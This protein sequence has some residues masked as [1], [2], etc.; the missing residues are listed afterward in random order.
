M[1]E[2]TPHL[3]S[4]IYLR[5]VSIF[6][7]NTD[8]NLKIFTKTKPALDLFSEPVL[9][10]VYYYLPLYTSKRLLPNKEDKQDAADLY[11]FHIH[12][13]ALYYN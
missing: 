6:P 2:R 10:Y 13:R 3:N 5:L 8:I 4:F 11:I 7:L 12:N 9:F 1:I